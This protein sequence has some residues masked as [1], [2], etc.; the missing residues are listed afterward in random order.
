MERVKAPDLVVE[1]AT[2]AAEYSASTES[3]A[4]TTNEVDELIKVATAKSG[5]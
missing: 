1:V 3:F 2:G 5:L 4:N